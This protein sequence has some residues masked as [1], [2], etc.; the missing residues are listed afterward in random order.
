MPRRH[1]GIALEGLNRVFNLGTVAALSEGDLLEQ[2]ITKADDTAFAALVSRHG[3]MVLGV[4]RRI[5]RDE[6]DVEDAFQATFLVLVRRA[7]SIRDRGLVSNWLYGVAH[8]VAV[9]AKANAARRHRHEQT[10]IALDPAGDHKP[11]LDDLAA[12][13]DQELSRLPES[14]R[15]PVLYCYLEGLTHDEAALKLGCPVGTVRSRMS[16]ARALLERRLTRR[17]VSATSMAMIPTFAL[18]HVSES[19]VDSTVRAVMGAAARKTGASLLAKGVLTAML[20]SRVKIIATAI[21]LGVVTLVGAGAVAQQLSESKPV[22][23]PADSKAQLTQSLAKI[24]DEE[25]ALKAKLVKVSEQKR[26]LQLRLAE[27]IGSEQSEPDRVKPKRTDPTQ[28]KR[29]VPSYIRWGDV[30][31]VTS[32]KGDKISVYYNLTGESK[33]IRLFASNEPTHNVVP[34]FNEQAVAPSIS[35]PKIGRIPVFSC[36]DSRW[37]VQELRET[38]ETAEPIISEQIITYS[39]GRYIY[40]FSTL[41]NRWDVLELPVGA[42]AK[43]VVGE[44]SATLENDGHIY[45]FSVQKG[46]WADLDV[47]TILDDP[48]TEK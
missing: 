36:T 33:P 15:A 17:G 38:V 8:R 18:Q 34:N 2:F 5:L 46:K 37:H 45:D 7:S 22:P 29:P 4:C 28:A 6:H 44:S 47:R 1:E 26:A 39:L 14:L 42:N 48:E 41:A 9:R 13:L 21:V 30:I 43:V 10:G 11:P 12:I 40:A 3:P 27:L 23:D 35:G 16:R 19:L 20:I 31:V 32:S 25:A 24:Q